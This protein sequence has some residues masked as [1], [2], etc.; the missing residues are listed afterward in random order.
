MLP[1]CWAAAVLAG[2]S[3]RMVAA[4]FSVISDVSGLARVVLGAS[5]SPGSLCAVRY[6]LTL[7][8]AHSLPVVA[9]IAWLPPDGDL[10]ERRFPDP[11][12]RRQWIG[13]ARERL[14]C[15]LEAACGSAVPDGCGL[16]VVIARSEPGPA[17]V[18]AADRTDDLLVIGAGR[19]G[20]LSR[21]WRG[22]VTRYC[23]S[24]ARCP[25]LAIPPPATARELGLDHAG[26]LLC[27][28]DLTVD[29]V[30]RDADAA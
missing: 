11:D 25:V 6:G 4:G 3:I 13:A 12:L 29:K 27:S 18:R 20:R 17:L 14:Y 2:S 1:S 21:L 8:R 16:S 7:A 26:R 24:H 9:V 5:G 22:R 23:L 28:Q 30:L 19:R 10:A 15:A